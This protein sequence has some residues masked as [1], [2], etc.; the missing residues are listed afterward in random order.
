MSRVMVDKKGVVVTST[1]MPVIDTK[2]FYLKKV[3]YDL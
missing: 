3:I 2:D 1:T